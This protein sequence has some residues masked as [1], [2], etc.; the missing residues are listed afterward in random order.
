MTTFE[1]AWPGTEQYVL[2]KRSAHD[3]L[4]ASGADPAHPAFGADG[5]GARRFPDVAA[6]LAYQAGLAPGPAGECGVFQL[7]PDGRLVPP[8]RAER[9]PA[10]EEEPFTREDALADASP[11]EPCTVHAWERRRET[12][13]GVECVVGVCSR[14]GRKELCW[15]RR[16]LRRRGRGWTAALSRP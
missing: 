5:A 13:R 11:A 14:C 7:L 15:S 9:A 2:C 10:S 1:T 6:A 4:F 12:C 3:A 8:E 16:P